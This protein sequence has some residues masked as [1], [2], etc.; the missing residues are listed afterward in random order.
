M[1]MQ[2]LEHPLSDQ[3]KAHLIYRDPLECIQCILH[4]PLMKDHI[5]FKPLQIFKSES[6]AMRIYTEWLS[7]NAAWSM[8]CR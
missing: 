7:G 5:R 6:R 4:N 8:Q 1:A 2:S 3:K